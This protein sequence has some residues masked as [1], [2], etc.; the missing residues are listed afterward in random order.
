MSAPTAE[1][2]ALD[3]AQLKKSFSSVPVGIKLLDGPL[4]PGSPA[5]FQMSIHRSLRFGEYFQVW[6]GARDNEIEV[7][8]ADASFLQLVLRVKEPR[9]R[10]VDVV[11]KRWS[12]SL[13]SVEARAHSV[14]GRVLKE[15]RYDWRVEMWTPGVD[16][17]YLCGRDDLHL[18]IAQVR[19]GDTVVQAHDSLK[20]DDVRRVEGL[21]P[22]TVQRQG[23]WFFLPPSDEESER[24]DQDLRERSRAMRRSEPVGQGAHPH[25]ADFVVRIDQRTRSAHR[26]YRRPR[27]YARGSIL[28]ADHR[29]LWLDGWRRVVRNRE[30]GGETSQARRIRWID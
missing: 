4:H 12:T 11:P 3:R 10:Y 21:T 5:I 14:G 8:S 9:R 16:R 30:I 29:P 13:E 25:L 1:S 2:A 7:L 22:G 26:E 24:L 18:F 17:R 27:V 15:T 20:P 19:D 23:E 6:P 28:H